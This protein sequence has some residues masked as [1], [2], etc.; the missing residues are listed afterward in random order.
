[1]LDA[2]TVIRHLNE[3]EK[4]CAIAVMLKILDGKCKMPP[5]EKTLM[6]ALYHALVPS[7]GKQ[8]GHDQHQLI[9]QAC[10]ARA[11]D[12]LDDDLRNIVYEQRLFAET[13][14]SRPVMKRFKSNLRTTG[15]LPLKDIP[16]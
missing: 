12:K 9:Q 5:L 14:I 8:L 7:C 15:Y 6:E 10:Q 1:M 16:S 2:T 4:D 13:M 3:D 11:Q